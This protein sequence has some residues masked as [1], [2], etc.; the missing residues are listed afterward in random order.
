M[1]YDCAVIGAGAAGMAAALSAARQG[2]KKIALLDRGQDVGGILRQCV[3]DGF[4]TLYLKKS[5]TGPEY[6]DHF[7]KQLKATPV[8]LKT[9]ASVL[10]VTKTGGVF[11]VKYLSEAEGPS[12]LT[13][14][15]VILSMG[16]RERTLGQLHI[17][18]SRPAGIY[19]AGTAQYMMNI[20]NLL[21]G[22]SA[23]I[24]GSGDIGLIMAR[25]LTLEG[26]RVK[27]V[28][29]EKAT[30]LAR[31][32][33][34]CIRDFE[35]PIRFGCTVVSVHGYK[36]LKG[37]SIAPVLENGRPDLSKKNY[38]PCDTLLVAAGLIPE[39]DILDPDFVRLGENGGI[40]IRENGGTSVPGLFACGNV[41]G[42]HDLVD[43]VSMAGKRAGE[44]AAAYRSGR[45]ET[46]PEKLPD[47]YLQ[48]EPT[49]EVLNR[50]K[51][52]ERLCVLCPKGCILSFDTAHDPPEIAG[53]QC[54]RGRRYGLEEWRAPKRM[55]T[56]T[57]KTA[58]G[59]L[60]PVKSS[61]PLAQSALLTAVK[62]IRKITL[63]GSVAPGTIIDQN[64]LNSGVDIITTGEAY[65]H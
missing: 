4:G 36:R 16:C 1:H 26:A 50:L 65:E 51:E 23:V 29:G 17:P 58:S 2:V 25:R 21:P 56:T 8:I 15:T 35:L 64:I 6:A 45:P 7:K 13:A 63:A 33:L 62:S 55:L 54:S 60:V 37:V 3:H 12:R 22:K 47:A 28:L 34:Q 40:G 49:C 5:L 61:G 38:I 19:T 57:V 31:N 11:S 39:T 41:T 32:H 18:G 44:A 43:K 30:G 10:D 9:G 20:Q 48:A 14:D 52:N 46:K 59:K 24:L 42:V 53:Y 27:L